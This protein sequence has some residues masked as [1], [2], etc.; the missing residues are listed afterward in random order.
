MNDEPPSP[1][2]RVCRIDPHSGWCV[3]CGR[4]L[5]EIAGWPDFGAERKRAVLAQL[6]LRGFAQDTATRPGDDRSPS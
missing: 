5:D 2:N 3:G 4:T 6:A 1:C